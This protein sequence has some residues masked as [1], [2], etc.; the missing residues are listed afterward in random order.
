MNAKLGIFLTIK[1]TDGSNL[2]HK[3]KENIWD[4]IYGSDSEPLIGRHSD[5]VDIGTKEEDMG[6]GIC[7]YLQNTTHGNLSLTIRSIQACLDVKYSGKYIVSKGEDTAK[8]FDVI[9]E[10]TP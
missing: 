1:K 7:L 10:H 5:A 3:E 8:I 2:T 9:E 4:A 6:Y